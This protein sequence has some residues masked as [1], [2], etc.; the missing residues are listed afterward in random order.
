MDSLVE[1]VAPVLAEKNPRPVAMVP[2]VYIVAGGLTLFLSL[3]AFALG[4]DSGPTAMDYVVLASWVALAGALVAGGVGL[5]RRKRWAYWIGTVGVLLPSAIWPWYLLQSSQSLASNSSASIGPWS[6]APQDA[7]V[8][9]S[10]YLAALVVAL[11]AFGFRHNRVRL[12]VIPAIIFMTISCFEL[13]AAAALAA[14]LGLTV[15][16]VTV[17]RGRVI[18]FIRGLAAANADFKFPL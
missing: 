3:F 1:P 16:R 18:G 6:A 8:Y 13:P 7:A 17:S 9:Y 15:S 14:G 2:V 11:I 10:L 12:L 5:V 4:G